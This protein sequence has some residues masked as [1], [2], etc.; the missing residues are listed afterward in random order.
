MDRDHRLRRPRDF[1]A[2]YKHGRTASNKLL[3]VRARDN[4][5][6]VTRVGVVAGKNFGNAV[7]RNRIK[8]RLRAL[9]RSLLL[10]PAT[11]HASVVQPSLGR[12]DNPTLDGG[13]GIDIVVGVRRSAAGVTHEQLRRSLAALLKRVA[14]P[15]EGDGP[16]RMTSDWTRPAGPGRQHP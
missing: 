12:D 1:A 4:G 16:P 8:R 6:S 11:A 3:V 10:Q 15:P 2:A 5:T 9:S 13:S 14:V 7:Q